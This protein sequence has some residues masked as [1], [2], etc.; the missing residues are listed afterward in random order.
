[1]LKI[2]FAVAFDFRLAALSA[3]DFVAKLFQR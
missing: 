1:M 3:L 2:L